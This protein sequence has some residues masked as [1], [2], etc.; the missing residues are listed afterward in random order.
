MRQRWVIT[1][2]LVAVSF[3]TFAARGYDNDGRN[4]AYVRQYYLLAQ[5]HQLRYN[6]PASITLAQGILESAAGSSELAL[7]ANNHFGIEAHYWSGDTV[8]RR[9]RVFRKYENVA[10]SFQDHS[11]FLLARRYSSL[12]TLDITDYEGWARG[13]QRCGYA[14]DPQYAQSLIRVIEL[15]NLAQYS[16]DVERSILEAQSGSQTP[17]SRQVYRAWGLLYVLAEEGDSYEY[18]AI[19]LGFD[20]KELLK[21]NDVRR[22][23]TLCQGDIVYLEKKH[24]KAD[25]GYDTH[26]V[27]EGETLHSISQ[28]YG[29]DL[30]R[31]ARR[32]KMRYNATI[33]AGQVL[34]L[35]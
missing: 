15:N 10:E 33:T 24:R 34:V 30:N 26:I 29:V 21:Y 27:A 2:F 31:L 3:I 14:E 16:L 11:E 17:L 32:N 5:E 6:I 7:S 12:F 18:I 23:A 13:L 22:G 25:K 19:Q 20:V 35:R 4:A 9:G 1:A 28:L 8:C